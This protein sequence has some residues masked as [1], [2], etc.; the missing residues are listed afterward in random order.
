MKNQ[1]AFTLIEL[2]VVVL[3][4][5]VLTA[6][7]LPQFQTAMDKSRYATLMPLAKSVASAQEAYY[8]N[9]GAYSPDL[10]YLDVQLPAS[11]AGT[12]ANLGDGATVTLSEKKN[13]EY[14]KL[15]KDTLENNYVIYQEKSPNFPNEIHCEALQGS[16]RA[17][18]L[19]T[20]LGGKKING[21]LKKGYDTYVLEGAGTDDFYP[22][23]AKNWKAAG[24]PEETID[25]MVDAMTFLKEIIES[26]ERYYA[27]HGVYP[28][29]DQMDISVPQNLR[30]GDWAAGNAQNPNTYVFSCHVLNST[31]ECIANAANK[32]LPM[33]QFGVAGGS[34]GGSCSNYGGKNATTENI[35]SQMTVSRESFPGWGHFYVISDDINEL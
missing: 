21:A 34:V 6:I 31:N 27:E 5:G 33:F 22:Q 14:V 9:T 7:A 25:K 30:A 13:Y 19:C 18:R 16:A 15:S 3:I 26:R 35:C 1:N 4:I 2:L 12:Q 23:F 8:M 10:A 24:I 29:W 17:E 32:D 28:S 20:T 11:S